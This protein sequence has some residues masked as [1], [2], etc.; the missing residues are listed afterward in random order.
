MINSLRTELHITRPSLLETGLGSIAWNLNRKRTR[1]QFFEVGKSYATSGV[2][3]YSENLHLCLY[4]TGPLREDS[5]KGKG[6]PSDF[7]YLKSLCER[8]FQI[9]GLEM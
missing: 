3:N 8:I 1:L 9:V 7:Y 4:V 2:G 5:W 6:A